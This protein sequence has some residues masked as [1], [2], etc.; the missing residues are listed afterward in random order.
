[1][2]NPRTTARD[3]ERVLDGLESVAARLLRAP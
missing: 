1:M 3:L 2:M